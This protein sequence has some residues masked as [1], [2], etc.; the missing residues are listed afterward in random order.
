MWTE[1]RHGLIFE[2]SANRFLRGMVRL[3]VGASLQVGRGKLSLD[4]IR[5]AMDTQSP[6]PRADSAPAHG[7]FLAHVEYPLGMLIPVTS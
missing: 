2:I 5:E 3:I 4:E 7:L 6:I 1:T